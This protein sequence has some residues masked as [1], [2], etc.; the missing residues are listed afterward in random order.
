MNAPA[1]RN[2]CP[3]IARPMETGD[4]LLARLPPA[5]P[6]TLARMAALLGAARRFGN[7][8]VEVSARGS[9]QLRG[10][11]AGTTTA[12]AATLAAEGIVDSRPAIHVPPLAGL[13][14]GE[15]PGPARL[16]NALR[17]AVAAEGL[18]S[19]L[20]PKLSVVIDG[21]GRLHLD[22]LDADLRIYLADGRAALSLGGDAAT[23]RPIGSVPA[24]RAAD[25]AL[26]VLA[27][28]AAPGPTARGRDLDAPAVAAELATTPGARPAPRAPAR[29]I[30]LHPL[31]DG[32]AALGFGLPFG[33]TDATRMEALLAAATEAGASHVA[34]APERTL[35]VIGLPADAATGFRDTAA[36]LGFIIDAADPRRSVAA[37]AGAPACASGLMSAR[38]IAD[39]ASEAAQTLLDGSVTL[40]LSGCA[41]GCARPGP[42]TLTLVGTAEGLALAVDGRAE[43]ARPTGLAVTQA[44]AAVAGLAHAV[45]AERRT[46]ETA[47]ETI[48]RLGVHRLATAL[49]REPADA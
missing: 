16:R 39:A 37:C 43:A 19:R 20:A 28:L 33:S 2:A 44:V 4:G 12:F 41:K 6:L 42:A 8:I 5:D 17:E 32:R 35:L 48:A 10:L 26:H 1:R 46:G 38:D 3:T 45:G 30:G 9:L 22:A 25:A 15:S 23:A 47:A 7:G 36:R 24:A 18:G 21:P 31:A 29:T 34:P 27:M 13:A 49:S 11:S 14:A 40:H